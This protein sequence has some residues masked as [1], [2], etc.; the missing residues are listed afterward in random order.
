MSP[1][2]AQELTA[3]NTK[4]RRLQMD[5]TQAGLAERSSVRLATL[6][7]F[8]QKG[9]ISL[10]SF[11]KL[12]MVLGSLED[13]VSATAPQETEFSSIDEVIE[14]KDQSTRKRGRRKRYCHKIISRLLLTLISTCS[15]ITLVV[16]LSGTRSFTSN[17]ILNLL[18]R[19]LKYNPLS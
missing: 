8:E 11:L 9:L 18:K 12:H 16:S 1:G 4:T 5:R 6:R 17:T 15:A 13:I 7:K 3:Q 14:V 19:G 2:K 10:E